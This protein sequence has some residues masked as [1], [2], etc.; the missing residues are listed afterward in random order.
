MRKLTLLLLALAAA[1]CSAS[2]ESDQKGAAIIAAA[3]AATGGD[4]WDN[5]QIWH[6]TGHA[7]LPSGEST[8]YEH[9]ADLHSLKTRNLSVGESGTQYTVFDGRAAYQSSNSSFQP[10]SELNAAMMKYGAYL[11]CFGFFFPQRFEASFRFMGT[12]TDHG[13]S[14]DVVTVSPAGLDSVDVWVDQKTHQI[15][16]FVYAKGQFQTVLSDYR[17]VGAVSVPFA[18]VDDGSRIRT[19]SIVFEPEDS[20]IFSVARE[21]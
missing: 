9:W 11:A 21:Q 2:A 13:A 12:H 8:R 18:S 19:D 16:R 4:A 7:L 17:R 15:F 1:S 5:I 14:Y 20:T 6:E 10:R 3:K